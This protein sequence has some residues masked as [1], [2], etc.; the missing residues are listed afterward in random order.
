MMGLAGEVKVVIVGN[1]CVGKTSMIRQF[2][3]GQYSNEYKKTIGV[4][5]L[6]KH[7]YV[8][9]PP[10]TSRSDCAVKNHLCAAIAKPEASDKNGSRYTNMQ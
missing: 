5:F 6:E 10:P 3:K 7:Q 8:S 4:D 9:I 1:G 2:C